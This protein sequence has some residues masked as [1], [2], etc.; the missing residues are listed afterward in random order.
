MNS[1][2]PKEVWKIIHQILNPNPKNIVADSNTLNNH[3]IGNVKRLTAKHAAKQ[4]EIFNMVEAANYSSENNF[5]LNCVTYEEVLREIRLLRYDCSTG[6][7]NIPTSILK[8]VSDIIASSL[9]HIINTSIQQ[10]EI[11]Q[12]SGILPKLLQFQ[13]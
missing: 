3:F 4:D 5:K 9:T 8:L 12:I 11:F 10:G 13:K 7:D 2:R 6:L 1:N